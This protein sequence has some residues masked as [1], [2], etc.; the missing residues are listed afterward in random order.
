M[1]FAL[2]V[3]VTAFLPPWSALAQVPSLVESSSLQASERSWR[4]V[5]R[6]QSPS[7]LVAYM[8]GC[9]PKR[10]MTS[11]HDAI[12]DG[13]PYVA[14]GKSI[15]DDVN[16]PSVCDVGVRAAIFSDG[17]SE[18]D[19]QFVEE[20]FASRRGAYQ[21]LRDTIKLL[22]SVYTQHVAIADILN[23][24]DQEH[25][26]NLQSG[27]AES[28]GYNLVLFDISNFLRE[29][30]VAWRFPPE[31]QGQKQQLPTIE[32]VMAANGLSH[33]EARVMILNKRLEAWKALLGNN[34][35]PR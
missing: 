25:Q 22:T 12:T 8:V 17:H 20:L 18:G 26:S 32:D 5:L 16:D 9:L 13:G 3:V 2:L 35:Q 1:R 15:E 4:R 14:P 28:G 27:S 23:K 24:L 6:N 29:P 21:A 11:M 31:Y 33:D 10:G 7:S 19:P 30:S 34:L